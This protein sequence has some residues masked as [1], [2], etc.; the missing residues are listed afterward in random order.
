MERAHRIAVGEIEII[1]VWDGT[2]H[3]N[4]DTIRQLDPS[5]ARKRIEEARRSTGVDPLT[6]PVLAFLVRTSE[7]IALIDTGSGNT[8]GPSMGHL[9]TSLRTIGVEPEEID[10][11]LLTHLHMDHIG[12]LV[13]DARRA[14]FPKAQLVIHEAEGAYFL[15]TP[16]S[17][18][19]ARS[20]R[21]IDFVRAAVAA[22]GGR[23]RRVR[24][25][26]G[27]AGV[28]A[29]LAAGHT[30]GHTAWRVS[31][32]SKTAVVLGD[33][34]HLA[35]IQLP[36]PLTPM[37]Y[38]IDPQRAGET[39]IALLNEIADRRLLVAGAHLP[40]PGL[41]HIVRQG[42]GFAFEPAAGSGSQTA[43]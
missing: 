26:E 24:D 16:D 25:G 10:S 28:T 29:H 27:L 43:T 23:V 18:L 34:V 19:D 7:H 41:G 39:R 20:L 21:N 3:A 8:K 30:P 38:D 6:L 35:A 2:L 37:I 22:Y 11:V 42:D 36:L 14:A 4:L 12:G 17:G 32:S 33:V 31:S 15:D 1:S 13:D 5:E 9:G 40:F